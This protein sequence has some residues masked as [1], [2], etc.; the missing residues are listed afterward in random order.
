MW[1]PDLS[2]S[3]PPT[4]FGKPVYIDPTL[5]LPTAANACSVWLGSWPRAFTIVRYGRPVL[6]RDEVTVKGQILLYSEQRIGGNITDSSACKTI[7]TAA[8]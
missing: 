8:S 1:Q 3:Q 4:L 6:I 5:P 2:A 7:K